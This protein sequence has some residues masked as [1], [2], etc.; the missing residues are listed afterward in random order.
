M[1]R[2]TGHRRG[3]FAPAAIVMLAA[4]LLGGC[5]QPRYLGTLL[6]M[7]PAGGTS[8]VAAIL[9]RSPAEE[10]DIRP[11]DV[12]TAI[13][14]SPLDSA[15]QITDILH[16]QSPGAEIRIDLLRGTE[17]KSKTLRLGLADER[18]AQLMALNLTHYPDVGPIVDRAIRPGDPAQPLQDLLLKAD[19]VEFAAECNTYQFW[20]DHREP[21]L[22]GDGAWNIEI[23]RAKS[24]VKSVRPWSWAG[25]PP[26]AVPLPTSPPLPTVLAPAEP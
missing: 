3:G 1:T 12:V 20:F 10:A 5:Q 18:C 23:D 16:K 17:K 24:V 19:Q 6:G 2:K 13:N 4:L 21:I 15:P 9:P 22:I 25:K 7:Q 26:E 11:R 8:V 14:G